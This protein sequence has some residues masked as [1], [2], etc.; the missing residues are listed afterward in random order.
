M[1][2]EL[3]KRANNDECVYI[4]EVRRAFSESEHFEIIMRRYGI[5]GSCGDFVIPVPEEVFNEEF[6]VSYIS[7][8]IFNVMSA[9]SAKRLEFYLPDYAGARGMLL[10]KS[11]ERFADIKG[12]K[13]VFNIAARLTAAFSDESFDYCFLP[14]SAYEASENGKKTEKRDFSALLTAAV[15]KAEKGFFCGVDIGGT[16]IKLVTALDGKIETVD[17]LDW[18]P[19]AYGTAEE[20]IA[21]IIE[22][23]KKA[24]GGRLYDGVGVSFPDVVIRN[25]IIGGETPKTKG[26]RE[27]TAL[28][29]E[30]EFAKLG[31]LDLRIKE[32][33]SENAAV[34]IIND[35]H[36]A[37]FTAAAEMNRAG[38]T[39][40]LKNGICAFAIGTD[41][42]TGILD[43]NGCVPEAPA[44]LYDLLADMGSLPSRALDENDLRC[45]R[46]ENSGLNGARRY[47]G[48]ASA[49]RY[50]YKYDPSLLE[51]FVEKKNGCLQIISQPDMRKPCLEMLMQKAAGGNP[52]AEE[53]FV[54]IGRNFGIILGEMQRFYGLKPDKY[55]I[56]GRFAKQPRCFELLKNGC[57]QTA[58]VAELA[59]AD[60][61]M[62]NT[63]LMKQLAARDGVSV[64]QYGQ[65]VGAVYFALL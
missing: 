40:A 51:G 57:A 11:L 4:P 58:P 25:R 50:A 3:L 39:D 8:E 43:E 2:T 37:A 20:I 18:N 21:P 35:G 62:A 30:A 65:A 64:A 9:L 31:R 32:L 6:V 5:D 33:C 42:G 54:S 7:A 60:E 46:N 34:K 47:V 53:I 19:A 13:K 61:D 56:F 10:Q 59:A 26:M 52:A 1:Y 38:E 63:S 14:V 12:Y 44:E 23:L 45:V 49:F 17:I 27:N 15:E 24:A 29:Y 41:L 28:D 48:Q 16:D 22:M 55:Y 36:M